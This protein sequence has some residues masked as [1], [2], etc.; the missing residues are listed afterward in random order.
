MEKLQ[1]EQLD[2]MVMEVNAWDGSLEDYELH[3]MDSFDELM[4]GLTPLEIVEKLDSN[5]TTSDA[6]FK[7]TIYGVESLGLMEAMELL[8]DNNDEI[9]ERYQELVEEGSIEDIFE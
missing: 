7:F 5:F 1:F 8:E 4:G 3:D 6:Y 2:E 9:V